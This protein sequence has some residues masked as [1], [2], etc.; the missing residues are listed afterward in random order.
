VKSDSHGMRRQVF[1]NKQAAEQS[2][3]S[4]ALKAVEVRMVGKLADP[5]IGMGHNLLKIVV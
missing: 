5:V 2:A 1:Q 4:K 3:A